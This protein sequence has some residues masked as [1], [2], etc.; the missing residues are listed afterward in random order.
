[1]NVVDSSAWLEYFADGPN[2]DRFAAP[3]LAAANL[4]VP[5]VAIYEVFKKIAQQNGES[6]AL[7]A[8]AMMEQGRVVDFDRT[9]ALSAARISA[10]HGLP[11]ADSI[12]LATA[13]RH[14]ATLW[15]QDSDFT[16]IAGVR[17][18]PRRS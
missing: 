4:L 17:F 7:Q 9:L 13:R 8:V 15:T 18:Y 3:I 11:L 12:M 5:S 10:A 6:Q 2:A 14:R 16:N 1:M